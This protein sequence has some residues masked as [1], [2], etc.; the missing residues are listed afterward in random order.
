ML[1]VYVPAVQKNYTII[2]FSKRWRCKDELSSAQC[3]GGGN[4]KKKKKW[5]YESN[6]SWRKR[7]HENC[8][9]HKNN[10]FHGDNIFPCCFQHTQR[11]YNFVR[12]EKSL[13][14]PFGRSMARW[15]VFLC[16]ASTIKILS[17]AIM[18]GSISC[19]GKQPRM[20]I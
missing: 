11:S 8:F 18:P 16:A 10:M 13:N 14:Y 20:V 2:I 4:Q 15:V 6:P 1:V 17:F 9:G 19:L 3:A 5:K 7:H 12:C